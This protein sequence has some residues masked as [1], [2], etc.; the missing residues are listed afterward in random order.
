MYKRMKFININFCWVHIT[1]FVMVFGDLKISEGSHYQ[2]LR[3]PTLVSCFGEVVDLES[4]KF[5]LT[6]LLGLTKTSGQSSIFLDVKHTQMVDRRYLD[7]RTVS[8]C[9]Q[10]WQNS[11]FFLWGILMSCFLE[12]LMWICQFMVRLI[13]PVL[14]MVNPNPAQ[15]FGMPSVNAGL[16][17]GRSSFTTSKSNLFSKNTKRWTQDAVSNCLIQRNLLISLTMVSLIQTLLQA[18]LEKF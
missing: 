9:S 12:I 1:R 10:F 6:C 8:T 18:A 15:E 4:H 13:F 16:I 14:R 17:P 2:T 5:S 3:V 11:F 7:L